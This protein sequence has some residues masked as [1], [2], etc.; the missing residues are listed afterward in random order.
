MMVEVVITIIDTS[1]GP[2]KSS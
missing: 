1:F 2:F